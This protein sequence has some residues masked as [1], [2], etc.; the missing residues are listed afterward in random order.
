M[1]VIDNI[2][3]AIVDTVDFISP[4]TT[5]LFD[6]KQDEVQEHIYTVYD[7]ETHYETDYHTVQMAPSSDK[8]T[9]ASI[10]VLGA[11]TVRKIVQFTIECAGDQPIAPKAESDD[12]NEV[13]A[14]KHISLRNVQNTAGGTE[15]VWRMS[16]QY[17]YLIVDPAKVVL[18]APATPYI[19]LSLTDTTIKPSQF[20]GGITS[21]GNVALP[22]NPGPNIKKP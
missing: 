14:H 22:F 11:P 1:S 20:V 9:K 6:T 16:G 18:Q 12:D 19:N 3:T 5:S 15:A 21:A 8:E 7:V 4:D 17:I 10:A 13:L 2:T